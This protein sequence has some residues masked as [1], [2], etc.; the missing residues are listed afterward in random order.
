MIYISLKF[1]SN[2]GWFIQIS[3]CN[4]LSDRIHYSIIFDVIFTIFLSPISPI[5]CH[6]NGVTRCVVCDRPQWPLIRGVLLQ[7]KCSFHVR[8]YISIKSLLY[9]RNAIIFI[10]FD[11]NYKFLCDQKIKITCAVEPLSSEQFDQRDLSL[12]RRTLVA[13]DLHIEKTL[14]FRIKAQYLHF[15]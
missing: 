11:T 13:Q 6:K 14:I 15:N 8:I 4:F 10:L 7:C 3:M 1:T 2:R 5:F 12:D 9:K